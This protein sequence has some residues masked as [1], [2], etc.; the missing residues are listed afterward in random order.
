MD[1]KE[2]LSYTQVSFSVLNHLQQVLFSILES[3]SILKH[4]QLL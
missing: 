2:N 4:S 1:V 3:F